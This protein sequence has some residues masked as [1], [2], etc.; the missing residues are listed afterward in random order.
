[1]NRNTAFTLIEILVVIAIIATL[2]AILFPVLAVAKGSAKRTTAL[3]NISQIGKASALYQN[4]FDDHLPFRFP[5]ET[6]WR[7]YGMILFE[8]GPASEHSFGKLYEPYLKNKQVWFS[9]EDKLV[10]KGY[11]SFVFNEQLSFSWSMSS[12]PRP[13]EAIYL[14]DRTDVVASDHP[15]DTYVWWQFTNQMPFTEASLPG[16]IDPVSVATQIA[17]IRYTGNV[18]AYLFLDTHAATMPFGK[19]WGTAARNLHLATKP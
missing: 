3:E 6:Q 14:T 2:A 7:G 4:D 8:A 5:I 19:T 17:P 11:T 16:T 1:M 12:F 13:A 18:G 15:V 10:N 9:P